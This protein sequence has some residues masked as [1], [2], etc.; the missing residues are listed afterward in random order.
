MPIIPTPPITPQTA[1]GILREIKELESGTHASF[2]GF[3]PEKVDIREI[4]VYKRYIRVTFRVT[5]PGNRFIE[6][7]ATY[8]DIKLD[9][10]LK[11]LLK[12]HVTK[13]PLGSKISVIKED[14][15]IASRYDKLLA[16]RQ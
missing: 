14:L 3:K 10:R 13:C 2:V 5:T 9:A 6:N 8:I 7:Y 15:L 12:V 1:S 16:L 11:E 4:K